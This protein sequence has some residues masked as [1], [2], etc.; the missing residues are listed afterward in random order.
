MA[1]KL[2]FS[3]FGRPYPQPSCA[4]KALP[5]HHTAYSSC[6]CRCIHLL[7]ADEH[8]IAH[9][10]TCLAHHELGGGF[11]IVIVIVNCRITA[12]GLVPIAPAQCCKTCL[13]KTIHPLD[14]CSD[15]NFCSGHGVCNLGSCD[16]LDGF[17]GPD[18]SSQVSL[19]SLLLQLLLSDCCCS[20]CCLLLLQLLL[21]DCDWS[22]CE[23]AARGLVV[24]LHLKLSLSDCS[25]SF[26]CQ[27]VARASVAR[28]LPGRLQLAFR[29]SGV[30]LLLE[31]LLPDCCFCCCDLCQS[32]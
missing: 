20:I 17:G 31:R 9:Q 2:C 8:D 11:I 30:R 5:H 15:L 26:C 19:A 23:T 32:V 29:A 6:F 10:S 12:L 28:L 7:T 16:C 13:S 24:R 14:S 21:S 1:C 18:C 22:C 25:Q 27:T 4:L 3:S